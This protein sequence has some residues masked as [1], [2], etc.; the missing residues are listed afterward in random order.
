MEYNTVHSFIKSDLLNYINC[1]QVD[2]L[3][4]AMGM[5]TAITPDSTTGATGATMTLLG[6]FIPPQPIKKYYKKSYFRPLKCYTGKIVPTKITQD[7]E[8]NETLTDC[9][10][11]QV[12]LLPNSL[13]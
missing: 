7:V 3:G 9:L 4:L 1:L 6:K 11:S 2:F 5:D 13:P 12:F 10:A 8:L